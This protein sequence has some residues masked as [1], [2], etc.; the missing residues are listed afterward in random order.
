MGIM[1]F[2]PCLDQLTKDYRLIPCFVGEE[3]LIAFSITKLSF[4]KVVRI[5]GIAGEMSS[6]RD[7]S[8]LFFFGR[9]YW[10]CQ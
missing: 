2:F 8:I 6:D 4:E 7:P 1:V 3:V 9:S 5:F 10:L